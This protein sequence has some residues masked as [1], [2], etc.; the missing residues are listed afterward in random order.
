MLP[1]GIFVFL[2]GSA[3][4]VKN[5]GQKTSRAGHKSKADEKSFGD[6]IN[7]NT[8]LIEFTCSRSRKMLNF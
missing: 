8:K 5:S 3:R 4:A 1:A 7:N 6:N 2:V